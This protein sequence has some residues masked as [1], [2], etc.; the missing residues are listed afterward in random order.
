M[1]TLKAASIGLIFI[2]SFGLVLCERATEATK[3][4]N[5]RDTGENRF[6]GH[7][8]L[9]IKYSSGEQVNDGALDITGMSPASADR[10]CIKSGFQQFNRKRR[11]LGDHQA[12]NLFLSSF[13]LGQ[14]V[15]VN[16]S[17]I[18]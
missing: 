14:V 16:C 6:L 13:K 8:S 11:G 12:L 17:S 5:T 10:V 18:P 2:T 1:V 3:P 15:S 7:W 4:S 9:H